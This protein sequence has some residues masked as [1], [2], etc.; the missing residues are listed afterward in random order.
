[1]T[2][3]PFHSLHLAGL[4]QAMT[5]LGLIGG[6]GPTLPCVL[7]FVV[8]PDVYPVY[9]HKVGLAV[10][11]G[12]A[13]PANVSLAVLEIPLSN[14]QPKPVTAAAASAT[15]SSGSK[16]KAE[17]ADLIAPLA[18]KAADTGCNCTTGCKSGHC[19]CFKHG[20][21][22]GRTCHSAAAPATAA[23]CLNS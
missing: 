13:L 9:R 17:D 20:N 2:V 11:A 22:C 16:R 6:P 14:T 18:K 23:A 12:R 3:S 7:Y 10:P 4:T 21:L 15:L 8:P 5:E 1:M 19:K